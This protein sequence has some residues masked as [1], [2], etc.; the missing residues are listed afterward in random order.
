MKGSQAMTDGGGSDEGRQRERALA[1]RRCGSE[2]CGDMKELLK[3]LVWPLW[4][5]TAAVTRM[6]CMARE[7]VAWLRPAAMVVGGLG[8]HIFVPCRHG[9]QQG[10]A[11]RCVR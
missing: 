7:S 10:T 2:A 11:I 1:A 6:V 5:P 8:R 4:S 9:A 3:V